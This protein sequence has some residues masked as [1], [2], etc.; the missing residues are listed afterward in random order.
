MVLLLGSDFYEHM[1][2]N[3]DV[4]DLV[5]YAYMDLR[6]VISG[7]KSGN[8]TFKMDQLTLCTIRPLYYPLSSHLGFGL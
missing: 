4:D 1:H 7:I 5:P 6:S 8:R 3:Y 2:T